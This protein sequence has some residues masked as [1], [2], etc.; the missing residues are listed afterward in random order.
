MKIIVILI[1]LTGNLVLSEAFLCRIY[2]KYKKEEFVKDYNFEIIDNNQSTDVKTYNKSPKDL[3][4]GNKLGNENDPFEWF[5]IANY[6]KEKTCSQYADSHED[7]KKLISR[8]V[9]MKDN[10]EW[11]LIFFH[12]KHEAVECRDSKNSSYL[13][14]RSF[15]RII[16]KSDMEKVLDKELHYWKFGV[17]LRSR[18]TSDKLVELYAEVK[19]GYDTSSDYYLSFPVITKANFHKD[20]K[21]NGDFYLKKINELNLKPNRYFTNLVSQFKNNN[22]DSLFQIYTQNYGV[23]L[24]NTYYVFLKE[25]EYY[26]KRIESVNVNGIN[27]NFLFYSFLVA[28][29]NNVKANE[30]PNL[31]NYMKFK[32]LNRI[33]E[34]LIGNAKYDKITK[35]L[36]RGKRMGEEEFNKFTLNKTYQTI[37]ILSTTID[38]KVAESFA[39]GVDITAPIGE[40]QIPEDYD[41]TVDIIKPPIKQPYFFKKARINK[42]KRKPNPLNNLFAPPPTQN[43]KNI[44]NKKEED[45]D[46]DEE[47]DF[48]LAPQTPTKL[49]NYI[50][51]YNKSGGNNEQTYSAVF[52]F[53]NKENIPFE[54]RS[55]ESFSAFKHEKEVV[56][57]PGSKFKLREKKVKKNGNGYVYGYELIF[58]STNEKSDEENYL[59]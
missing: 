55:I 22:A 31:I 2:S 23:L 39:K 34:N 47:L 45:E 38:M 28:D 57:K 51:S 12:L 30:K 36:Y 40:N 58:E 50:Q 48:S 3:N 52:I 33:L 24:I 37:G 43:Q 41:I 46:E 53:E 14:W 42:S 32:I 20:N 35:V 10:K 56:F 15:K 4:Q 8:A 59:Y 18:K 1:L 6:I 17:K 7:K 19:N 44:N 27:I 29:L 25:V 49:A 5:G 21:F 9:F 16:E 13:F 26:K 54:A 11:F